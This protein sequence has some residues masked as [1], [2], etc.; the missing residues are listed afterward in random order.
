VVQA[1][2]H[3]F[4]AYSNA[5]PQPMAGPRFSYAHNY[6]RRTRHAGTQTAVRPSSVGYC[7]IGP[8]MM[9]WADGYLNSP[10]LPWLSLPARGYRPLCVAILSLLPELSRY[11]GDDA[12]TRRGSLVGG[13]SA[14]A[15]ALWSGVRPSASAPTGPVRRHVA[16]RR[17]VM[18]DQ[19]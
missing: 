8:R 6:V 15:F 7:Q 9:Q 10:E 2:K 13:D 16:S 5:L 3:G 17:G 4:R 19:R 11:P 12:G 14:V 18:Q 1:S